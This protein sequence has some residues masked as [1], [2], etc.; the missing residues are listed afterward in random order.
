MFI[1]V[2]NVW[3]I[4]EKVILLSVFLDRPKCTGSEHLPWE[5]LILE[6]VRVKTATDG[7]F[8]LIFLIHFFLFPNVEQRPESR[9]VVFPHS[10]PGIQRLHNKRNHFKGHHL[11]SRSPRLGFA[12]WWRARGYCY[13]IEIQ[14]AARCL[15]RFL[16]EQC[17]KRSF[18]QLG[19]SESMKARSTRKT[20]DSRGSTMLT[21]PKCRETFIGE[22]GTN[23]S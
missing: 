3:F 12:I 21:W 15:T 10:L 19:H 5:S 4:R 11:W 13:H 9:C 16:P 20:K 17:L 22:L 18:Q 14:N 23:Q 7:R 2:I 6:L 1:D 8:S